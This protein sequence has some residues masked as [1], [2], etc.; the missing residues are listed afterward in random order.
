M[1]DN[2]IFVF[3]SNLSGIHG[4]G[5]AEYAYRKFGAIWGEGNGFT[6]NAY[7]IPTKDARIRTLPLEVI[8]QYVET[9]IEETYNNAHIFFLLTKVG[10]GF[11]GYTDEQMAPMF[12]DINKDNCMVPASWMEYLR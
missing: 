5:A 2:T 4:A 6:G 10:C 12:K 3:G 8:G 7:A 9:F 1:R 11:A